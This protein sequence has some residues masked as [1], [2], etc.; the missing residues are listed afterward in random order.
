MGVAAQNSNACPGKV[1]HENPAAW[2]AMCFSI[3]TCATFTVMPSGCLE[4]RK[5]A[6][7]QSQ[8]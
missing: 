5:F 8:T 7:G 1:F 6:F 3:Q 2:I 4:I